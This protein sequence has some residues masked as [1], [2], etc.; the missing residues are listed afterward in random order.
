MWLC[1]KIKQIKIILINSL[2]KF[3]C[4]FTRFIEFIIAHHI[5]KCMVWELW[6]EKKNTYNS[7]LTI[8]HKI[9]IFPLTMSLFSVCSN[10]LYFSSE[11]ISYPHPLPQG[12]NACSYKWISMEKS[13]QVILNLLYL[14]I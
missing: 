9:S 3:S 1:L 8:Y 4:T 12:R 13:G 14:A 6:L 11:S 10:V 5:V 7:V 2:C